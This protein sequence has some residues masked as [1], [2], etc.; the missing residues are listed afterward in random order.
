MGNQNVESLYG[1]PL[2]SADPDKTLIE[3]LEDH[4]ERARS[5]E[6]V[7]M[8]GI[9]TYRDGGIGEAKAGVYPVNKVIGAWEVMKAGMIGERGDD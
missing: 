1:H 7:A 5:G 6:I 3:M 8:H 2:P 9:V 4:L